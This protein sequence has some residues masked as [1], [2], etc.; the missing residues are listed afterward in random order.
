MIA[1]T[2]F[3]RGFVKWYDLIFLL[4]SFLI[5]YPDVAMEKV[6]EIFGIIIHPVWVVLLELVAIGV[7]ISV[8][9]LLMANY[10]SLTWWH[11]LVVVGFLAFIRL[12]QSLV[13][14]FFDL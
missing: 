13:S 11:P 6:S 1:V 7:L 14:R 3:N 4:L 9:F 10:P 8:T 2:F 5:V 12:M